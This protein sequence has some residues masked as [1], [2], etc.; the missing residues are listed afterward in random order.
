[1]EDLLGCVVNGCMLRDTPWNSIKM[2]G[3]ASMQIAASP[4]Y[5]HAA[6]DKGAAAQILVQSTES[7]VARYKSTIQAPQSK[8]IHIG[9]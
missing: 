3:E 9:G 7:Q 1:M 2:T 5:L 8:A 6:L 4:A